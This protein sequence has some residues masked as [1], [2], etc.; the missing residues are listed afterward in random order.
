VTTKEAVERCD[1]AELAALERAAWTMR[2][3]SPPTP[4]VDHATLERMSQEDKIAAISKECELVLAN[5][6]QAKLPEQWRKDADTKKWVYIADPHPATGV[7]AAQATETW[8][9]SLRPWF[10]ERRPE[11]RIGRLALDQGASVL[12]EPLVLNLNHPYLN[13]FNFDII[14]HGNLPSGSHRVPCEPEIDR[15]PATNYFS[16]VFE[17]KVHRVYKNGKKTKV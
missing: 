14:A 2:T 9:A 8:A 3:S 5:A 10:R 4:H 1:D 17:E 13:Y 12:L 7:D 16:P 11:R 15:V 6:D